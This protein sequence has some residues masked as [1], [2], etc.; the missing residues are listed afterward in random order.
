[1]KGEGGF[2]RTALLAQ[3]GD[4]FHFA[5]IAAILIAFKT[6]CLFAVLLATWQPIPREGRTLNPLWDTLRSALRAA[7]FGSVATALTILAELDRDE[8][9]HLVESDAGTEILG[10]K[11]RLALETPEAVAQIVHSCEKIKLGLGCKLLRKQGQ[12]YR[13]ILVTRLRGLQNPR[14]YAMSANMLEA[15]WP[16][17]G[18]HTDTFTKVWIRDFGITNVRSPSA[19]VEILALFK[20]LKKQGKSEALPRIAESVDAYKIAQRLSS[21]R[22][23]EDLSFAPILAMMLHEFNETERAALLRESLFGIDGIEKIVPEHVFFDVVM[24]AEKTRVR[25]PGDLISRIDRHF[26]DCGAADWQL[27]PARFWRAFGAYA[28]VRK[29]HLK[30]DWDAFDQTPPTF[31]ALHDPATRVLVTAALKPSQWVVTQ[32]EAMWNEIR[33]TPSIVPWE[34][35]WL[36]IALAGSRTDLAEALQAIAPPRAT[37]LQISPFSVTTTRCLTEIAEETAAYLVTA[38]AVLG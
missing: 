21:Y 26:L 16:G 15:A 28:L 35:R 19:L 25:V 27:D 14:R 20:K 37:L 38:R 36:V 29:L 13:E 3:N 1:M 18:D 17:I 5:G 34:M 4:G 31:K 10:Y 9:L 23:V 2:P 8:T 6:Q 24:L 32:S 33:T 22:L 30:K 12:V 7:P 11:L